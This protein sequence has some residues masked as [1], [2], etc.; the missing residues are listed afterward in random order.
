MPLPLPLPLLPATTAAFFCLLKA[1][2]APCRAAETAGLTFAGVDRAEV[3]DAAE[4]VAARPCVWLVRVG[5][6]WERIWKEVGGWMDGGSLSDAALVRGDCRGC[7]WE[8]QLQCNAMQRN[9]E[10]EVGESAR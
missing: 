7:V 3:E 6:G 1:R 4:G 9:A 10:R 5:D 2:V 8:A